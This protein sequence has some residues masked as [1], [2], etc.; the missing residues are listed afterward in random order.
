[1]MTAHGTPH[2]RGSLRG[3][4][5][6]DAPGAPRA[7]RA[8]GRPAPA[9]DGALCPVPVVGRVWGQARAG[10]AVRTP[11][12]GWRHPRRSEPSPALVAQV[13]RAVEL[14]GGFARVVRPGDT[15][16]VKPNFNSGDPPPN[17]SD[18][19]FLVALIRLLRDHGA[20]RVILGESSRHPPTSTR[21]EMGRTGV[22]G[23]CRREGVAVAVFGEGEWVP[24]R[25]RGERFH[26]LE[27]ARPL[28]ECDRLVFA[29]C[30]KT[31]WLAKFS[32]SI[33]H[34]VG[35]VRPRHR[36]LLHFGGGFAERIA[37]IAAAVTPD[38]VLIDARAVYVRGGPCYGLVRF[39]G[40][41]L[42]GTDRV[43][44]DVEGI[45]LLQR[46][47]ECA[48]TRDPWRYP[49]IQAAVRLGLGAAADGAYCVRDARL[50]AGPASGTAMGRERGTPDA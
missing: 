10:Y 11:L 7:A 29:C 34:A 31:H 2:R 21:F 37:E 18:V 4:R 6:I 26:T 50:S 16:L 8:A 46:Y 44:L 39:P 40:V 42:A 24:V 9:P 20:G 38:L 49:Q 17:S 23:A 41:V 30:L 36:A 48:L 15:V 45:R 47:P 43:A 14:A 33:K 22:L 19:P 12:N 32:A 28:L 25:G 5:T 1:M 3:K 27:I 13:H 35:C